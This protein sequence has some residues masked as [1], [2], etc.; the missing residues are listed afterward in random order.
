MQVLD[1]LSRAMTASNILTGTGM[2]IAAGWNTITAGITTATA[3]RIAT[4]TTIIMT[5]ITK[6]A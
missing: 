2:E 5:T 3:T 1:G 4:A 6:R